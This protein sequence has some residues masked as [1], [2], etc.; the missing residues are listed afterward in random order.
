MTS[1]KGRL[2]GKV[3]IITGGNRG[4]GLVSAKRFVEEGAKVVIFARDK[5]RI[6]QA[7]K[8]L[9]GMGGDV[10]A[11]A[12]SVTVLADIDCLIAETVKRFGI[13]DV[14]F[15]NHG[16]V[17]NLGILDMTEEMYHRHDRQHQG[18]SR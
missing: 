17:G 12:G 3:A 5:E 13:I 9:Q 15:V 7:I 14:V 18:R 6:A 2:Q 8:E 10:M 11:V 4:L 1:E 16:I